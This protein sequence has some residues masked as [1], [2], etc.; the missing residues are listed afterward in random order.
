MTLVCSVGKEGLAVPDP[1]L[2]LIAVLEERD[3]VGCDLFRAVRGTVVASELDDTMGK[4]HKL[5]SAWQVALA[6]SPWRRM[7]VTGG[8]VK[9]D[10]VAA[11]LV[12]SEEIWLE[13]RRTEDD[14]ALL[15]D[16]VALEYDD[17]VKLMLFDS[18][19]DDEAV[20]KLRLSGEVALTVELGLIVA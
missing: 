1:V 8:E 14:K 20:P 7:V 12:R 17:E 15:G 18:S 9:E 11:A 3:R 4:S 2:V 10:G 16:T 5:S 13:P 19:D 6:P